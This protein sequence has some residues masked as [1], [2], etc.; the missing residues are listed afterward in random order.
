MQEALDVME[1]HVVNKT[2]E[3][4]ALY[5]LAQIYKANNKLDEAKTLKKE[6]LESTFELG[7]L[8]AEK[9]REI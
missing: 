6:L 2:F 3:P 4:E 8:M 1:K 5:H 9:I 7:P